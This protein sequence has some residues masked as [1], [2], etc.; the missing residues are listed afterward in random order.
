LGEKTQGLVIIG[1]ILGGLE[2][3]RVFGGD[4]GKYRM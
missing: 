2:K 4:L 1:K 3:G